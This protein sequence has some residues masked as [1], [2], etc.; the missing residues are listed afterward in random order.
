MRYLPLP[1]HRKN[2]IQN[3]ARRAFDPGLHAPLEKHCRAPSFCLSVTDI[4]ECDVIAG[5]VTKDST[6]PRLGAII[7]KVAACM[8]DSATS[9]PP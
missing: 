9:T 4:P 7:G 3:T 5:L 2:E 1:T 8:K 6:P